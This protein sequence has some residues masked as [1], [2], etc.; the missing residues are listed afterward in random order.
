MS[1]IFC[2][3]VKNSANSSRVKLA[4]QIPKP[5]SV[6]LEPNTGLVKYTPLH[7]LPPVPAQWGV[8]NPPKQ[9]T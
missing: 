4:D 8:T 6:F 9:V 7:P 5:P 2:K 1:L 3:G